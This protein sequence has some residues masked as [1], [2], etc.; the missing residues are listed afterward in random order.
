MREVHPLGVVPYSIIM[1]ALAY[2]ADPASVD[3][4]KLSPNSSRVRR[5]RQ[6]QGRSMSVQ[7]SMDPYG[8]NTTLSSSGSSGE[9]GNGHH[10]KTH[11]L[12]ASSP[13]P[14]QIMLPKIRKAK[15]QSFRTHRRSPSERR[16]PSNL[17][18]WNLSI[19]QK[20]KRNSAGQRSPGSS[21]YESNKSPSPSSQ[22]QRSPLSRQGTVRASHRRKNSTSQSLNLSGR[23]SPLVA[24]DRS[25]LLPQDRSPSGRRSPNYLAQDLSRTPLG[26]QEDRKSP[27]SRS[28]T[29]RRSPLGFQQSFGMPITPTDRRS[30]AKEIAIQCWN[31][32]QKS[33]TSSIHLM[34]RK[35]PVA[36]SGGLNA[37][38]FYLEARRSPINQLPIPPIT[39]SNPSETCGLSLK[40]FDSGKISPVRVPSPAKEETMS[41]KSLPEK[42]EK[43]SVMKEILAFVR[44]PSK[45]VSS[46]TSRFAAAFSR[47]DNEANS[48][49]PLV[50]QSTFSSTPNTSSRAGRNAITKQMSYE[51]KIS[52]KLKS[53]GSK[54]S[55]R[56]R[57]ATDTK[58][59][60][61]KSSGDEISD[62]ES[63][64][65]GK[66]DSQYTRSI[67]QCGNEASGENMFDIE[68]V[69][70]EKVGQGHKKHEQ[71]VEEESPNQDGFND[72]ASTSKN[73]LDKPRNLYEELKKSIE[74]LFENKEPICENMEEFKR[75]QSRVIDDDV[76]LPKTSIQCPTFEIEPPSRRASFDPPRSPFLEN[77]RSLS[78][79]DHDVPSGESFEVV[80]T[81][82]RESSF[83]GRYSSMDTSFDISRYQSTS[84][85][86]Q[87]SSFEIVESHLSDTQ[88]PQQTLPIVRE[89]TLNINLSNLSSIEIVD[90]ETFAKSTPG[91]G[92]KSSLETHFDLS[93]SYRSE[94]PVKS[95]FV[96][97]G[98]SECFPIGMKALHQA[99]LQHHHHHLPGPAYPRTKSPILSNQTSSNYSSRDSY[100]SSSTYEPIPHSRSH[101]PQLFDT[102]NPFADPSKH[103]YPLPR[104]FSHD[105]TFLCIDK[106]C[107]GIFEP[108]PQSPQRIAPGAPANNSQLLNTT[109]TSSGSEFEAPSPRRALSASP[110]H[111][112]TFRIV[113]K[114]VESSPEDLCIGG[115][116]RQGSRQQRDRLRRDSRRRK[117]RLNDNKGKSF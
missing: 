87:T 46:R 14:D 28:P 30:P 37:G 83:E 70:F 68:P 7:S 54:M 81:S 2:Q 97:T 95:A 88:T 5:A 105:K 115:T 42:K 89:D 107:A 110:K 108:R 59:K 53:V 65:G 74:T 99:S 51:P 80:D 43:T 3:P 47:S 114:K 90:P 77:F 26:F 58:T 19:D 17:G 56:L 103:H 15:S 16:S 11:R 48:N 101:T 35:S 20:F 8:S 116:E 10:G 6:S 82:H 44:K 4:G 40:S 50:R 9:Q 36:F 18:Q 24:Q 25:E 71:I 111:T 34:E 72:G 102:K 45:K 117:S 66:L 57:R 104:K 33:P 31:E 96:S 106:R 112:F 12:N 39:I 21:I 84:Y 67:Y 23:R 69:F 75:H 41:E 64:D 49:A 62:M 91:A 100:D 55:L 63:S 32:R 22:S 85:D 113:M 78:D 27:T 93:D 109:D 73:E 94:T 60:E 92:R 29:G 61:K 38:A 79:T 86:D 76:I 1:N 98:K 13:N 52:S